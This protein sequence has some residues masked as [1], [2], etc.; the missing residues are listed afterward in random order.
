[1]QCQLKIFKMAKKVSFNS[2]PIWIPANFNLHPI[3]EA[4]PRSRSLPNIAIEGSARIDPLYSIERL[5][6]EYNGDLRDV[7]VIGKPLGSPLHR[8]I[9]PFFAMWLVRLN[10]VTSRRAINHGRRRESPVEMAITPPSPPLQ[11]RVF[12]YT[13]NTLYTIHQR[14]RIVESGCSSCLQSLNAFADFASLP[15]TFGGRF[16]RFLPCYIPRRRPDA[17]RIRGRDRYRQKCVQSTSR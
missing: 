15:V 17:L 13:I 6:G 2:T 9:R 14:L 7:R 1:M 10:T 5:L 4:L 3:C 8:Q 12:S 16:A 11:Q